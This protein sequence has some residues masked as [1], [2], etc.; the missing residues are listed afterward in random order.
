[1]RRLLPLNRR[2]WEMILNGPKIED[3]VMLAC[4][5]PQQRGRTVKCRMNA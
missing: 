4:F 3:S 2:D 5:C 1:L